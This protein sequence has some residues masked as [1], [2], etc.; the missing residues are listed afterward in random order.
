MTWGNR[1]LPGVLAL[2]SSASLFALSACAL[3][4]PARDPGPLPTVVGQNWSSEQQSAWWEGSQG[5]RLIPMAWLMALEAPDSTALFMDRSWFD[6]FGYLWASPDSRLPIGFA[7]DAQSDRLFE[8]TRQRWFEGQDDRQPWVGLNCAACHT[9]RITY[10]GQSQIVDGAPT[11]ADFQGFTDALTRAMEQTAADPARF[12]RFASRVLASRPAEGADGSSLDR[13]KGMLAEG[14]GKLL[15]HQQA[16][17]AYNETDIV[18]GHGR[19]DAVGHILNKVALLNRSWATLNG[20]IGASQFRLEPDAPVSYPFIWNAHQHDFVQWNGLVP[21]KDLA[22]GKGNL[23]AGALVRNTSEVIGVFAE[24]RTHPYAG[25]KGYVSSVRVDNLNRM[26]NQLRGLMSPAW[27][28]HWG[29]PWRLDR[30]L[31]SQGKGLFERACASCHLPLDR[32]D[33]ATPIKAQ[34]IPIWG[35]EGVETDPGMVCNTFTAQARGGLLTGTKDII[36]AGDPLPPRAQTAAYLKTQA[37]GVLLGQKKL[38]AK[39]AFRTFL[40]KNP[41][42]QVDRELQ[43]AVVET[44]AD[45]PKSR[46]QRLADCRDAAGSP[47]SGAGALRTLAYKARPLN[48]IWATAPYLHNGSVRSLNDLLLPHSQRPRR[49]WVGN[50]EFDPVAVGFVDRRPDSG[51]GS[52]FSTHDGDGRPI[53]GNSNAGHD[54]KFFDR[55]VNPRTGQPIGLR[56]FTEDERKALIEYM[57]QL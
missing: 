6:R 35:H 11:L 51:V 5:S 57:K 28:Q 17:R 34:M 7:V 36:L 24:V 42:I 25:L 44:V 15:V 13:D 20:K 39:V 2:A 16:L 26:E 30:R 48:G 14:L 32:T 3:P 52:E 1:N 43:A 10:N 45:Q 9:N 23:D 37:V 40:G 22:L 19:L 4:K 50:H 56:D 12:D 8:I 41:P 49:F 53:R 31:V 46:E 27:P 47:R 18:Y 38:L 55:T 21:N 29:D 54:Y 33:L